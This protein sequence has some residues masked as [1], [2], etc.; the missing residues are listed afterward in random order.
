MQIA[1]TFFMSI[2]CSVRPSARNN[3]APTRQIFI[4]F[5]IWLFV[6]NLP[7]KSLFHWYRTGITGT[8]LEDQYTFCS[9][10]L[11][12]VN[13]SHRSCR[14]KCGQIFLE[15]GR[16]QMTIFQG[17]STCWIAK[18]TNKHPQYVTLIVFLLHQSDAPK[19]LNDT[20]YVHR[21]SWFHDT[22]VPKETLL[23]LL[24][25]NVNQKMNFSN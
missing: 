3:W 17:R 24:L 1:I 11:R 15:R 4:K 10:P 18:A 21:H 7:R 22:E 8:L 13:V 16:T 20:L 5:D 19:R 14:D 6:K 2:C 25:C 9:V 23:L 12:M